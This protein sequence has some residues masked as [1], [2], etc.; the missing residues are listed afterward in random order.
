MNVKVLSMHSKIL[1]VDCIIYILEPLEPEPDPFYY[2]NYW[3]EEY[4]NIS[5]TLQS[6][7]VFLIVK[8]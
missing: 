8:Q 5:L 2:I 4:N 3:F 1:V 6:V 7:D